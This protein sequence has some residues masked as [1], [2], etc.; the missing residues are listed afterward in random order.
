[1]K[2]L[3]IGSNS[4][5]G[6]DFVR[7]SLSQGDQVFCVSRNPQ[8]NENLISYRHGDC[9][10]YQYDLNE[11]TNKIIDII[12]E[13]NI[14]HII[15]FAAQSIVEHSWNNPDHWYNTNTLSLCKLFK[16]L[17]I[18]LNQS[19]SVEKYIQVSTPEVY[20][21]TSSRIIPSKDY[22][23][24]TPYAASKAAGDTF[25]NM[26]AKHIGIP[27]SFVRSSNVY[28]KYQQFFKI[29]P[30]CIV[31]ILL[32]KKLP[33][34]G[35]GLSRRDFI[36]IRDVSAAEYKVLKQGNDG[37]VYHIS[38]EKEVSILNLI[39]LI[40]SIM[41]K[42]IEDVVEITPDRA[43]KDEAYVLDSSE[44][45]DMKWTPQ[46]SLEEGIKETIGWLEKIDL[47]RVSLEYEHQ[48]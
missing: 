34:H 39:K 48:K 11:D 41:N 38:T 40:C 26:Y 29:I 3:V 15:N 37:Q 21:T 1:M 4:F 20:G 2:I 27:V 17:S 31:S 47:S 28:G 45:R 16:G 33:L 32:N 14:T 30:K 22:N 9:N 43:G 25:I 44:T 19:D 8:K 6:Q 13:N 23:P 5:S 18:L 7:H 24:T 10:F 12:S 36:H 35:G 42:K 46:I